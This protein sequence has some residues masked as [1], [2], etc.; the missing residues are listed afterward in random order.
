MAWDDS[1]KGNAHILALW[2]ND[3]F[4]QSVR[5][6]QLRYLN[7]GKTKHAPSQGVEVKVVGSLEEAILRA[8]AA[9]RTITTFTSS[10]DIRHS[11]SDGHGIGMT[12]VAN[13]PRA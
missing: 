2:T 5:H 10:D 4:R 8:A 9:L 12:N 1:S 13:A 7:G 3:H 11:G 6:P